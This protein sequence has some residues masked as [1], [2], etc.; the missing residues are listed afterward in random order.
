MGLLDKIGAL[1]ERKT[2]KS[3]GLLKRSLDTLDR[4]ADSPLPPS[5]RRISTEENQES[6]T[7]PI[8]ELEPSID[9]PL[10]LLP[11]LCS[12]LAC[13]RAALLLAAEGSKSPVPCAVVGWKESVLHGLD[14]FS[15]RMLDLAETGADPPVSPESFIPVPADTTAEWES[16]LTA[17]G[18]DGPEQLHLVPVSDRGKTLA[19]ILIAGAVGSDL[20]AAKELV[21]AKAR[22]VILGR[23]EV[24]EQTAGYFPAGQDELERIVVKTGR[25]AD[26]NG[27]G[28]PF[29]RISTDLLVSGIR[30]EGRLLPD[31][32]F[33]RNDLMHV[34]GYVLRQL[35]K[36]YLFGSSCVLIPSRGHA[37]YETDAELLSHQIDVAL[38]IFF[39]S[40]H[41]SLRPP[42]EE[43]GPMD[44]RGELGKG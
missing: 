19:V 11:V 35:G 39:R 22:Q 27:P 29:F 42:V 9:A 1:T 17:D 33:L 14:E 16:V 41:K 38:K 36:L 5:T 40:T 6:A 26:S 44:I 7:R 34:L 28:R 8:E 23:L 18:S 15:D 2:R 4:R 25:G 13:E 37:S 3:E 12:H 20:E 43:I 24:L 30:S 21:S 31:R 10:L 32:S